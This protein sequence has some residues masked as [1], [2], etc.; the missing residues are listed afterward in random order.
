MEGDRNRV[1]DSRCR[2]GR[3]VQCPSELSFCVL[4]VGLDSACAGEHVM[5]QGEGGVVCGRA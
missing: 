5:Q 3:R 4:V 1:G 2:A